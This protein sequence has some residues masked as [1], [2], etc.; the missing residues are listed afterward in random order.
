MAGGGDTTDADNSASDSVAISSPGSPNLV[1][2]KPHDGNFTQAQIGAIYVLRVDN[3]GTASSAGAVSVIDDAP[4]GLR[5][6][7]AGGDGWTCG[8]AGQRVT[9]TRADTLAPGT[10]GR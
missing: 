4:A 1:M 3:R 10:R 5:P 9:C 6:T 7:A 2:L 8:I